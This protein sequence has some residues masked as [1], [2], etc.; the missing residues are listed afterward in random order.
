[1]K[2]DRAKQLAKAE[3]FTRRGHRVRGFLRAL[4]HKPMP[5]CTPACWPEREYQLGFERGLAA[6]RSLR[7]A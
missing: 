3:P 1:M 7:K 5:F 6:R 4:R 2:L